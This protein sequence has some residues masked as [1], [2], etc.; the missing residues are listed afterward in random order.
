MSLNYTVHHT[1]CRHCGAQLEEFEV[2][3]CTPGLHDDPYDAFT[4]NGRLNYTKAR[5]CPEGKKWW[6]RLLQI[7]WHDQ[8]LVRN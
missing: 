3:S 2:K 4:V 6:K 8:F 5:R 1:H 7:N